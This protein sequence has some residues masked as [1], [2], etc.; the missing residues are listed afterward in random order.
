MRESADS[1][2]LVPSPGRVVHKSEVYRR[3]S[4]PRKR[5]SS[6]LIF[7]LIEAKAHVSIKV[8]SRRKGRLVSNFLV[9]AYASTCDRLQT[10]GLYVKTYLPMEVSDGSS[11]NEG[12]QFFFIFASSFNRIAVA[13]PATRPLMV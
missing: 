8:K 13:W 9:S 4:P 2:M 11:K 10:I 5:I 7:I 12:D 1:R 6:V 3:S